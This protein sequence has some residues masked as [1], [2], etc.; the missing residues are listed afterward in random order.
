MTVLGVAIAFIA[1]LCVATVVW[2]VLPYIGKKQTREL[3]AEEHGGAKFL[4]RSLW[5][6]LGE[7]PNYMALHFTAPDGQP[8]W[9]T[10]RRPGGKTPEEMV[11]ELQEEL[12]RERGLRAIIKVFVDE[13]RSESDRLRLERDT[14]R[15]QL[16]RIGVEIMP[17]LGRSALDGE[18]K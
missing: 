14:H 17:P 8:L 12:R 2:T 7:A 3:L 9:V 4:A 15:E 18:E 1:G 16:E 6:T 5:Q 10:I 11:T 13:M